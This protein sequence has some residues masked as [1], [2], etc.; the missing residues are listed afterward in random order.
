MMMSYNTWEPESNCADCPD[1]VE[2]YWTR[3]KPQGVASQIKEARV[4]RR[5]KGNEGDE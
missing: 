5:P 2:E 1:K 3:L 4:F